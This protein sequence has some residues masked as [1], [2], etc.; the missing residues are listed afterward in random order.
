[1]R[2]TPNE[3]NT[4]CEILETIDNMAEA[5]LFGSRVDDELKGGDIDLIIHSTKMTNNDMR[6]MRWQLLERL[7]E[8]KIDLVLSAQLDEP[9]VQMVLPKA[10]KLEKD[11]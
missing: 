1:M 11:Y 6:D 5:Y 9:F 4:I 7:G 2:L 10:I 8:Q 3:K